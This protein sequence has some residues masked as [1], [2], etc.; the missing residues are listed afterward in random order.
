VDE[1]GKTNAEKIGRTEKIKKH[2]K[3]NR[4]K[5]YREILKQIQ[6]NPVKQKI[7]K[8]QFKIL[9]KPKKTLKKKEAERSSHGSDQTQIA[10]K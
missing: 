2:I 8:G 7:N 5:Q 4:K 1:Y 6:G 10:E 9:G 3:S